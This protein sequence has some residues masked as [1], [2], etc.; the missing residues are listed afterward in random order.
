MAASPRPVIAGLIGPGLNT[1][2]DS[3][4]TDRVLFVILSVMQ[5]V[6]KNKQIQFK[7]GF[8]FQF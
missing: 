8:R 2:I 5:E 7:I 3:L 1:N 6:K 4:S